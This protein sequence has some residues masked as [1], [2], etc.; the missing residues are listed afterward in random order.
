VLLNRDSRT[1]QFVA[2]AIVHLPISG[3][4]LAQFWADHG[5]S[6]FVTSAVPETYLP[7]EFGTPRAIHVGDAMLRIMIHEDGKVCKLE[8]A[9]RLEGPW[10]AETEHAWRASLGAD[11]KIE[12]DL[13]QLTRIDDAGRDLLATIQRA[14][15]CLIVEGVWMTALLDELISQ[16]PCEGAKPQSLAKK[17]RRRPASRDRRAANEDQFRSES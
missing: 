13:R 8:L 14:G 1:S 10:V 7:P 9:G 11:R 15:A 2:C 16:Q 12:M 4:H 17:A 3:L 5:L 6:S